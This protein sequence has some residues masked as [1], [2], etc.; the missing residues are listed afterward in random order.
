MICIENI[1]VGDSH[2]QILEGHVDRHVDSLKVFEQ[3]AIMETGT[4]EGDQVEVE[5]WSGGGGESWRQ[6]DQ[7]GFKCE[8]ECRTKLQKL[9][10]RQG[11]L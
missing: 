9:N 3:S 11:L 5:T 4:Q 7:F 8:D 1:Y 10:S 6:E 2:N